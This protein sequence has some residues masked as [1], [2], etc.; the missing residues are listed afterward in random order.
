MTDTIYEK[1]GS[2]IIGVKD[3]REFDI[4]FF[5]DKNNS[6]IIDVDCGDGGFTKQPA[7]HEIQLLIDWLE[8]NKAQTLREEQVNG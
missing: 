4:E 6:I 2:L 1:D 5:L 7:D 3:W 8:K